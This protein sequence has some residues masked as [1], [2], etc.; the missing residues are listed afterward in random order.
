M[1]V[2]SSYQVMSGPVPVNTAPGIGVFIII[3]IVHTKLYIRPTYPRVSPTLSE[4]FSQLNFMIKDCL[5]IAGEAGGW[6]VMHREV[7]MLTVGRHRRQ[8][9]VGIRKENKDEF[10]NHDVKRVLRI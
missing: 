9:W 1:D 5:K 4:A 6:R 10:Q 3:A 8:P 7:F 2:D